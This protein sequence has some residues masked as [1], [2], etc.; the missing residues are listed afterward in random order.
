MIV[1]SSTKNAVHLG[2]HVHASL[3]QKAGSVYR[4]DL[5]AKNTRALHVPV[6]T[7]AITP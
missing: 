4:I 6:T 2:G 5:L 7:A 1:K 3:R